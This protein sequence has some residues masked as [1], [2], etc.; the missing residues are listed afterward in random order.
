MVPGQ[1]GSLEGCQ[2][3][4]SAFG[5]KQSSKRPELLHSN[6]TSKSR[7]LVCESCAKI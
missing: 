4:V 5:Q 6:L 3:G 1:T 7:L 2:I